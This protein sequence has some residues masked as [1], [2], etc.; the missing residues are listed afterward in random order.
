[1]SD[2]QKPVVVLKTW[3]LDPPDEDVT[4]GDTGIVVPQPEVLVPLD[5]GKMSPSD[6]MRGPFR[7]ADEVMAACEAERKHDT[8]RSQA[9]MCLYASNEMFGVTGV[10]CHDATLAWHRSKFKHSGTPPKGAHVLWTGGSHGFGHSAVS[11]GGG[12]VYS[13]DIYGQGRY[14]KTTI[15]TINAAWGLERYAGWALDFCGATLL[16]VV[17][18]NCHT[19]KRRTKPTV[20]LRL[21]RRAA[22]NDPGHPRSVK[23]CPETTALIEQWLWDEG[24][25]GKSRH[26]IIDGH[27][28]GTATTLW[29]SRW[30]RKLGYRGA[31]ADGIPGAASLAELA[32]RHGYKLRK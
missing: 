1:M 29:Y 17:G 23:N 21:A 30:Q 31:D 27:W 32:G 5:G 7:V 4:D 26:R 13:T 24:M 14:W 28:S 6:G 25:T 18:W 2:E 20:S 22:R 8:W 19:N 16:S 9:G 12:W 3:E 15:Q 11:A 10:S